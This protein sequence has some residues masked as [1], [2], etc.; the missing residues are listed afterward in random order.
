MIKE[1]LKSAKTRMSRIDE[2]EDNEAR[3]SQSQ[4]SRPKSQIRPNA[5]ANLL[6]DEDDVAAEPDKSKKGGSKSRSQSRG[7]KSRKKSKS[8]KS[9]G[10]IAA[11]LEDPEKAL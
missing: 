10:N 2:E 8:G 5:I 11:E 3:L 1:G 6:E 4:K 9:G 7:R